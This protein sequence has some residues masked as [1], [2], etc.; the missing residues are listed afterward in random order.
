MGIIMI[1]DD[2]DDD[3]DDS[4]SSLNKETLEKFFSKE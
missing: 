4:T 1:N 2:D 3:N